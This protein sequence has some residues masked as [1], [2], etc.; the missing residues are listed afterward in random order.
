MHTFSTSKLTLRQI[1]SRPLTSL[2]TTA[3]R[4]AATSVVKR[5]IATTDGEATRLQNVVKLPTAGQVSTHMHINTLY[6]KYTTYTRL[7]SEA[8]FLFKASPFCESNQEWRVLELGLE[9]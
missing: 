9:H 3:E 6:T 1:L 5:I 8:H 7:L 4:K 2:P